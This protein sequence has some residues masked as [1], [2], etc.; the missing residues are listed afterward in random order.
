[1]IK[2]VCTA[3]WQEGV[4][5]LNCQT[6]SPWNAMQV[7]LTSKTKFPYFNLKVFL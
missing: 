2:F 7:P 6:Q 5:K 4:N 3:T 1:M